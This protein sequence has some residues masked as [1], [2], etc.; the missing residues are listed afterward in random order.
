VYEL[1]NSNI[2]GAQYAVGQ[3]THKI[4]A[5]LSLLDAGRITYTGSARRFD[6]K[7]VSTPTTW[8]SLDTLQLK[9][10]AGLDSAFNN[11]FGSINKGNSFYTGLPTVLNVFGDVQIIKYFYIAAMASQ[12]VTTV[13]KAGF[14]AFSSVTIMPRLEHRQVEVGLPVTISTR[15]GTLQ[16][17]F[18]L[19]VS[20]FY[21]GS[22]NLATL[23]NAGNRTG[24]SL[25]MGG[26]VPMRK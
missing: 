18:Y 3:G 11:V 20:G 7:N 16:P 25:Y 10:A 12:R 4:R 14:K 8:G 22:D 24:L 26:Y 1:R 21:M 17:G 2:G 6:F 13:S 5:G 23:F 9:G 15:Y 19:R